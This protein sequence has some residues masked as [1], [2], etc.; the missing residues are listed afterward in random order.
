M[1]KRINVILKDETAQTVRR[2][3]KAGQ[4]SQFIDRAVQYYAATRSP[5][6]LQEQIKTAALRDRDLGDAV[7]RDW[8]AVDQAAWQTANTKEHRGKLPSR[9]EAKSISR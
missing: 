2:A 7:A 1:P 4:R 8:F 3:A 9:G 5:E 6:A